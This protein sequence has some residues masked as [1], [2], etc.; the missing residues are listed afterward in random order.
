MKNSNLVEY[1]LQILGK[2]R[3]RHTFST[4]HRS[5]WRME[6]LALDLLSACE[7]CTYSHD[8]DLWP[9]DRY[10]VALRDTKHQNDYSAYQNSA[11]II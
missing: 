11:T 3:G 10:P 5:R 8:I 2:C 4:I 7:H 9:S 6:H 1:L